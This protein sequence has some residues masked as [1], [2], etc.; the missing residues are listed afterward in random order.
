MKQANPTNTSYLAL[1]MDAETVT[2]AVTDHSLS[3]ENNLND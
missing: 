2:T 3:Q 1:K